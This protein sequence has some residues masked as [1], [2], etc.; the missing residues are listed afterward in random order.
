MYL[1]GVILIQRVITMSHEILAPGIIRP[2][3]MYETFGTLIISNESSINL[4]RCEVTGIINLSTHW[5]DLTL[6]I[7]KI[8]DSPVIQPQKPL[9][10]LDVKTDELAI[11]TEGEA[12]WFYLRVKKWY[13]NRFG[14]LPALAFR[15]SQTEYMLVDTSNHETFT[16]YHKT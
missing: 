8:I 3:N 10:L 13:E 9:S 5:R 15:R 14:S 1:L 12:K 6:V 16:N 4:G 11:P 2:K 7:L